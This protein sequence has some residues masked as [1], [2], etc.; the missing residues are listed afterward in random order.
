MS[1][2]VQIMIFAD[3]LFYRTSYDRNHEPGMM[4]TI[5]FCCYFSVGP[6]L[7]IPVYFQFQII[8]NMIT[9]GLWVVGYHDCFDSYHVY[10]AECDFTA[11][12]LPL[13]HLVSSY[14]FQDLMWCISYYVRYFLC[15]TQFYSVLWAVLLFNIVRYK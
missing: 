14:L 5:F 9:H 15:Y 6:P 7:L 12:S 10:A 8:Q 3:S 11:L 13:S 1:D 2:Y 4:F